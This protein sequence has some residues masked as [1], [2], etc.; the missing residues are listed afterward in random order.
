VPLSEHEQRLLEQ[1][2]RALHAED[3][4]LASALRHGSGRA[5]NGRQLT[6]GVITVLAGL[7]GLIG[8][9][10]AELAV[11]GVVGFLAML[12]GV[13]LLGAAMRA[14]R[15]E[16]AGGPNDGAA[17]TVSAKTTKTSKPGKVGK[18][19]KGASFMGKVEDRWRKRREDEG[20]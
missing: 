18:A 6:L 14:P 19:P 20:F 8:G 7:G 9:V 13:L 10:M 4:R 11:L 3:P 12:A 16:T 15:P 2:E 5:I 1:M 17:P